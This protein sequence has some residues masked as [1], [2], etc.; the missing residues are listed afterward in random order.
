M[1]FWKHSQQTRQI[2]FALTAWDGTVYRLAKLWADRGPRTRNLWNSR[3]LLKHCFSDIIIMQVMELMETSVPMGAEH[4]ECPVHSLTAK[5]ETKA[6]STNPAALA[7]SHSNLFDNSNEE[8]TQKW[9]L[10]S[11]YPKTKQQKV[12][13]YSIR[14]WVQ[15]KQN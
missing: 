4:S 1:D 9:V 14:H 6:D 11:I 2:P 12:T 5:W 3:F 8:L 10:L 15:S 7:L 13:N